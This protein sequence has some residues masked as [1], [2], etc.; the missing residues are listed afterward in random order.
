MLFKGVGDLVH[1]QR[2]A[3]AVFVSSHE[4]LHLDTMCPFICRLGSDSGHGKEMR[5][6]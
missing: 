4:L 5:F 2:Y 6:Q 3:A 1:R